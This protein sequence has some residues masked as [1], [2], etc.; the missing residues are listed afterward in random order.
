[1]MAI[2]FFL[3]GFLVG[4]VLTLLALVPARRRWMQKAPRA[5]IEGSRPHTDTEQAAAIGHDR[6]I[7]VFDD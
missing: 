5:G 6:G 1:M 2:E 7:E 4:A 3:F